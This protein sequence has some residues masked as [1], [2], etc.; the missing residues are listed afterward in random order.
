MESSSLTARMVIT[1]LSCLLA[2]SSERRK[3]ARIC[4]KRIAVLRACFSPA[5][6][7]TMKFGLRTSN[8]VS[9][10]APGREVADTTTKTKKDKYDRG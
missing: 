10:F 1:G 7:T 5:L 3:T 2:T 4:S 6:L 8:H 9:C